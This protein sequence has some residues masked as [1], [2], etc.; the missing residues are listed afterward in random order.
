MLCQMKFFQ[1]PMNN[2]KTIIILTIIILSAIFLNLYPNCYANQK[3]PPNHFFSNQASWFDPWDINVYIAAIKNGQQKN[4]LLNNLYTLENNPPS[5]FYPLYTLT[6][7]LFPST[8]QFLLFH[9]LTIPTTII[10]IL[11]IYK[12]STFFLNKT[13]SLISTFLITFA[14]GI[15]WLV[16]PNTPS[17]D[18]VITSFTQTS[19]FQRPHEALGTTLYILSL[20]SFYQFLD[21][22][23]KIYNYLS[24]S[25]LFFLIFFYPYYIITYFFILLIPTYLK[26]KKN[27]INLIVNTALISILTYLYY[28][29]LSSTSF[30]SVSTQTLSLPGLIPVITGYI[31]F[32]PFFIYNLLT[33]KNNQTK[34]IFLT[35]WFLIPF[36]FS[37]LPFGISRFYLRSLYLPLIII[38]LI[39]LPQIFN[40]IKKPPLALIITLLILTPISSI[41][42]FTKRL[43]EANSLNP[44]FYQPN[45]FKN[46]LT[47]IQNQPQN[48]IL[49]P[50]TLAN[51]IPAHTGKKV[52]FGHLIQSPQAQKKQTSQQLLL[53]S[54]LNQQQAKQFLIKNNINLILSPNKL[55]YPFLKT[56]FTENNIYIYQLKK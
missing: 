35:F 12:V 36:L 17:A 28:L 38:T 40:K 25:S 34:R 32:L 47:Y 49:A 45:S 1:F 15:G 31:L 48:N 33:L 42:I 9:L 52:Y 30:S 50:Y 10:L 4:L 54:V 21:S 51:Y 55:T 3:T 43:N 2:F 14:G 6:G 7:Y 20:I 18:L 22:K 39:I 19:L 8:N 27:I 44:W 23:N 37:L 24:I 29:H 53:D 13:N 56:V 11:L 41:F 5:L 16:F 26:S 46:A